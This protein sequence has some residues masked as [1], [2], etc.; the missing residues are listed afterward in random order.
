M[1]GNG[2]EPGIWRKSPSGFH[3]MAVD[4]AATLPK[5]FRDPFPAYTRTGARDVLCRTPFVV[6]Q[7]SPRMCRDNA[8]K[9]AEWADPWTCGVADASHGINVTHPAAFNRLLQGS[10]GASGA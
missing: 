8:D 2:E 7:K 6:G 5:Q 10:T 4:N 1:F 3:T 9:L